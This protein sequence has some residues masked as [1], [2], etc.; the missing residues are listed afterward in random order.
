MKNFLTVLMLFISSICFGSNELDQE[1]NTFYKKTGTIVDVRPV[2]DY[3]F[4]RRLY[5]DIAG[6]IPTLAEIKDFGIDTNPAKKSILIDKLLYSEDYTN[7][8]Y[9]FFGDLWRIRV[10]RLADN[11]QMKGY[12]Y[13]QYVRDS[14]RS[15][16]PYDIWVTEMLT[17]QDKPTENGAT[18]YLLRDDGMAFDNLALT[19]QI[20]IGK[21]ISCAQCHDDPFSDYTQKQFY[22]LASFFD[23]ENRE[24]RKDYR[25][26]LT[27]VDSEI[28]AINKNDRIDNGVRQL[29]ASNLVSVRDVPTKQVRYPADYK[30]TNAKPGEIAVPVSL[31]GKIKTDGRAAIAKWIVSQ[32]D[33]S[34]AITNR[35]WENIV[36]NNLFYPQSLSDINISAESLGQRAEVIKF[37][38]SYLKNNSYS[39]KSLI[40]LVVSSDFYSRPAYNGKLDSYM[41]QG[42]VVRRLTAYQIWDSMLTLILPDVNYTRINFDEYSTLVKVDWSKAG[43]QY[44]LDKQAAVRNWDAKLNNSFLKY[45]GV[46]LVRSCFNLK[47]QNGFIGLFLKE[48]GASERVLLDTTSNQGTVTQLL[49]L[50]NGPILGIISDKKSNLMKNPDKNMIFMAVLGR[51]FNIV[52]EKSLIE[53]Q[54]TEDLVWTLL[55]TTEFLFKK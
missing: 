3:T 40:R 46:E 11:I 17:A 55:N 45:N 4:V 22:E 54:K 25:D 8:F 37:L 9:N 30:Y 27:K 52:T 19:T 23:N 35:I 2:D 21:N 49:T 6:R 13:M 39:L 44:M 31:D 7:N 51:P 33:F 42:V 43:G 32:D 38:G 28:K 47:G 24:S 48:F 10:E 16:K 29:M 14:I 26:I 53:S 50:M 36:G 15:D 1:L 41:F 12:P 5:L 20:F 18:G 34:Y